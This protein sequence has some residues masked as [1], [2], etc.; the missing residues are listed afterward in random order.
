MRQPRTDR[1][2]PADDL[3]AAIAAASDDA[4]A[5]VPLVVWLSRLARAHEAVL[6]E[7]NERH[8]LLPSETG[9]LVALAMAGE[10]QTLRPS[11]LAAALEQTTGGMTATLRR[12]ESAGLVER[13][14]DPADGRVS[15]AR[16]T[17]RGREV[18]TRS[19]SDMA[20]WFDEALTGT[21]ARRRGELLAA[22]KDLHAAVDRHRR[23]GSGT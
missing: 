2:L 3:D 14:A 9:V 19:L 13:T 6:A 17:D 21:G 22:V 1:P 18:G 7:L 11:V 16:L 10:E 15:L 20:T 8:G 12:L 5:T 4:P 23:G